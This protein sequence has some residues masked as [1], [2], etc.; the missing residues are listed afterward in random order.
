MS[1]DSKAKPSA[2]WSAR[3]T[4]ES[5]ALDLEEGVFTWADPKKIAKSLQRSAENSTR[6]KSSPYRSAMSMLTFY[7]N[8]A[9]KN[10][11]QEQVRVLDVRFGHVDATA[12]VH[13]GHRA[14]VGQLEPYLHVGPRL[15]REAAFLGGMDVVCVALRDVHD[16]GAVDRAR[17]SGRLPVGSCP[18]EPPQEGGAPR[19]L[20]RA[21]AP[22]ARRPRAREAPGLV[23]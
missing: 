16:P 11:S 13:F 7:I 9:G 18:G 23:I 21:P 4:S 14:H 17:R 22:G 3:V 1:A 12:I 10:L 6:R 2:N 19:S 15:G 8:R 20:H 5:N